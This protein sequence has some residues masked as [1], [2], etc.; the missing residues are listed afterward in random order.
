MVE[1]DIHL[2]HD[3]NLGDVRY[4]SH[5]LVFAIYII[6]VPNLMEKTPACQFILTWSAAWNCVRDF[7]IRFSVTFADAQRL[8]HSN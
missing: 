7:L 3:F 8:P 5:P 6:Y 2:T 1:L 4:I